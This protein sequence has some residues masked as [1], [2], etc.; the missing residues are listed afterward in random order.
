MNLLLVSV[1][2]GLSLEKLEAW[3]LEDSRYGL[4][5]QRY[6]QLTEAKSSSLFNLAHMI[7]LMS[8]VDA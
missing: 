1:S 6:D 3:P 4:S 7:L 2:C 5:A 8:F